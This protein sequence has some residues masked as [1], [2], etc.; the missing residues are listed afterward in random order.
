[1]LLL[2]VVF[3]S[4]SLVWVVVVLVQACAGKMCVVVPCRRLLVL[5]REK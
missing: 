2:L 3:F 5:P 1:L 4:V